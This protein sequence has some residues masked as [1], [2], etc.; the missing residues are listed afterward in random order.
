MSVQDETEGGTITAVR[1]KLKPPSFYKVVLMN[2]DFT[3]MDFVV[4]ILVEIFD[5]TYEE[6]NQLMMAIHNKGRGVAGIFNREVAEHK[7]YEVVQ[8][9]RHNNHPLKAIVEEA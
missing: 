7:A 3:P 5:K 2:D 4:L 1:T 6:A 8:I 9:A